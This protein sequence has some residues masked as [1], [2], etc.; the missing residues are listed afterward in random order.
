MMRIGIALWLALGILACA[1]ARAADDA[2]V[3]RGQEVFKY[4]CAA[5]HA[6]GERKPGTVALQAKYHGS[7]PAALEQRTDLTPAM[8]KSFVRAGV[9]VMAP[10]RK[11]EISDA[12][13]NALAM[14]LARS[15]R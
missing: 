1:G 7:R 8:T 3:Q 13:L 5:C 9:S 14:Y 2:V 11:T 15:R 6:P 12:D 4:W 10:F